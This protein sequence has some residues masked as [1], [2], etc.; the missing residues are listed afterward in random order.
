M[1]N[2]YIAQKLLRASSGP[3]PAGTHGQENWFGGTEYV[4]MQDLMSRVENEIPEIW[5]SEFRTEPGSLP[6]GKLP[7]IFL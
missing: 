7:V 3:D 5:Q 2:V 4:V 6:Y 1:T